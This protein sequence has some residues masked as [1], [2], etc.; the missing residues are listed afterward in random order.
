MRTVAAM[1]LPRSRRQALLAALLPLTACIG[2]EPPPPEPE[3]VDPLIRGASV[4][5]ARSPALDEVRELEDRRWDGGGRLFELARSD[6]AEVRAAAIRALGRLPFPRHGEPVTRALCAALE[7]G[8]RSVRHRAVFALGLRRDPASAAA[9]IAA[10]RT[11]DAHLRALLVDAAGRFDLP[12][13]RIEVLAALA[14]RDARVRYQAAEATALWSTESE[15]AARV[16][17]ELVEALEPFSSRRIQRAKNAEEAELVWRILYALSRRGAEEGRAAFLE[18][19][20]SRN[21]LEQLFALR[22]LAK[23]SPDGESVDAVMDAL[24]ETEDWRCAYEATVALGRFGDPKAIPVLERTV[25]DASSHVRAG[26]VEALGAFPKERDRIVPILQ[27]GSL[28]LSA[29]VRSAALRARVRLHERDDA[30]EILDRRA[31]DED[32]IVRLAVAEMAGEIEG[33]GARVCPMLC[34]LAEDP[35][36]LVATRAI[37]SLGAHLEDEGVRERLHGYLENEDPG[38]RLSAVLALRRRPDVA[39]AGPMIRAFE[40]TRATAASELAFE[41]LTNLGAIGGKEAEALLREATSDRRP[42]VA[43]VARD[44]LE[45]SFD[46]RV[47]WP[48][49][50]PPVVDGP[51]PHPTWATNP[52]V[53]IVT[54]RGIMAFE[55]LPEEAPL[56]VDNF[57]KLVEADHYDGTT[58]HRVVP[59]FVV[60][61]GDVRGDGNGASPWRGTALRHELTPRS[62]ERG[63]LGMPRHADPDSG[64]SQFFVTHRPT[65]H[66]D[67]RYTLFGVL[68]AG[69]HVLDRIEVGDRILE[70]RMGR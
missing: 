60:Q 12:E 5:I 55:L 20:G 26:T 1:P 50:L 47:P 67:G 28:D 61:G 56:H 57:V 46:V 7:D 70:V 53:E 14:D 13:L 51:V 4:S 15:D 44:V 18:Y 17:R 54:S 43:Q 35:S 31:G 49:E 52:I 32:P 68:R 24:V 62:Y 66:L 41:L 23:L 37:E 48:D 34:K 8:D 27:R 9:L 59:D 2:D 65:P 3:P 19:A 64:G 58:F 10:L 40:A 22:G 29:S 21:A 25:E 63:A 38:K 30:L 16:N 45:G 39:D 33:S 36:L 69:G 42:W 6:H 11:G